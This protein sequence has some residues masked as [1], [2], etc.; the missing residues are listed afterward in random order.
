MLID[1]L[2]IVCTKL[3]LS[4]LSYVTLT[5]CSNNLSTCLQQEEK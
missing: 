3:T 2:E 4:L 1:E 5:F